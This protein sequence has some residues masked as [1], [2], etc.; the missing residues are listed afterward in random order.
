MY[1]TF[2]TPTPGFSHPPCPGCGTTLAA[3]GK[4]GK[5]GC[6]KC[7]EHFQER[8][9]SYIRRIH[10]PGVHSGS[11]PKSAGD[12]LVIRRKLDSL[13]DELASAIEAQEFEACARLRDEINALSPENNQGRG[14]A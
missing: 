6:A 3:I 10:G 14:T 12:E 8:L 13:R 11:I 7:Y 2:Q 4:N 5:L 1:I 9:S